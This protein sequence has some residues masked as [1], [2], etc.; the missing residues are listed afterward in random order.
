[1]QKKTKKQLLHFRQTTTY[2]K[3]VR[4][5]SLLCCMVGLTTAYR[6]ILVCSMYVLCYLSPDRETPSSEVFLEDN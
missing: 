1:M 4:K 2:T 3:Y 5:A 6:L